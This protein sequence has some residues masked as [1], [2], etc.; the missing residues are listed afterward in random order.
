MS[1][2]DVKAIYWLLKRIYDDPILRDY[3]ANEL[4]H[5]GTDIVS[6]IKRFKIFVE[7]LNKPMKNDL[8]ITILPNIIVK[9]E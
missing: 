2:D 8:N 5:R 4:N 7:M 9:R 1:E 3:F 6:L